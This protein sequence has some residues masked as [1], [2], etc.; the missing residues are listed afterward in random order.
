MPEQPVAVLLH[1]YLAAAG[2]ATTAL[3]PASLGHT[4]D[5]LGCLDAPALSVLPEG[6]LP[7]L[8]AALRERSRPG[9]AIVHPG[10]LGATA[11]VALAALQLLTRDSDPLMLICADPLRL[12]DR[13]H[14]LELLQQAAPLAGGGA[15][16][17]LATLQPQR[18][19]PAARYQLLTA[20][21]QADGARRVQQVHLHTRTGAL[22]VTDAEPLYATGVCLTRASTCLHALALHTPAVLAACRLALEQAR[23]GKTRL[24][25]PGRGCAPACELHC[26]WPDPAALRRATGG[27]IEHQLLAHVQPHW[28]LPCDRHW[29]PSSAALR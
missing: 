6:Q 3:G 14:L 9:H 10:R 18:G 24:R 17:S 28:A 26:V 13:T 1:P 4:L 27:D 11:A 21:A 5:V 23:Q 16:L 8:S 19:Q 15:I 25:T 2:T 12:I 22:P 20:P 7:A 29:L